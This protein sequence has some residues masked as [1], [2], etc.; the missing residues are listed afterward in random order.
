M[1]SGLIHAL[2]REMPDA[3]IAWLADPVAA[4]LLVAN[5]DLDQ[6]IFWSRS[7]WKKLAQKGRIIAL[8]RE[9]LQLRR[10]L[11]A[12]RFDTALDVQGLL[13]SRLLAV[14]SGA[15]RRIG[16]V[17]KE[18]GGWLMT[19][20]ESRGPDQKNMGSEYIWML[21]ALGVDSRGFAPHIIL[22]EPDRQKGLAMVKQRGVK[23]RYAVICPFTTRPQ[24][25]WHI[26]RWLE[27]S[28][29]IH[30][31]LGWPVVV[32][33][34]PGDREPAKDLFVQPSTG[35]I[36]LVGQT[37]LGQAAAVVKEASVVIGVDTGLTHLG[38]AFR[39]PTI[40]LFGS[41][42][43]YLVTPSPKTR[44]IYHPMPCSPCRRTP[45]C[46]NY[47]CMTRIAVDEVM[48]TVHRVVSGS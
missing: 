45:T 8:C 48:T 47:D 19:R 21:K 24:K 10:A 2:R 29:Q 3:F 38:T 30:N 36:D 42:C 13:K 46:S 22:S 37:S 31:G 12:G 25:H 9:F 23:K 6:V 27:V 11:R 32:L 20:L 41:T 28:R 40:A 44:I 15:P 17:S 4:D 16:F 14:T 39:R 18:P 1:A 5:P 43:P 34:G 33:G 35:L 26:S 7:R